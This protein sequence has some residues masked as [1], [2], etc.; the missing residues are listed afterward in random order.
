MLNRLKKLLHFQRKKKC[1]FPPE[2][3][4]ELQPLP[5]DDENANKQKEETFVFLSILVFISFS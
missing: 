4:Q 1:L 5:F 3:K 2:Q